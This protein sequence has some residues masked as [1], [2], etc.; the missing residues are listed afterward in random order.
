MTETKLES[1]GDEDPGWLGSPA[2]VHPVSELFSPRIWM[3]RTVYFQMMLLRPNS[4]P[5]A[6]SPSSLLFVLPSSSQFL[7]YSSLIFTSVL[8]FSLE[9]S[10][11]MVWS[12][13]QKCIPGGEKGI[14]SSCHPWSVEETNTSVFAE[15]LGL[16]ILC[17]ALWGLAKRTISCV[18]ATGF[19]HFLHFDLKETGKT[20]EP[21]SCSA[22]PKITWSWVWEPML[23]HLSQQLSQLSLTACQG[24]PLCINLCDFLLLAYPAVSLPKR[25]QF[26]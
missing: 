22:P 19:P 16:T 6:F 20:R 13:L 9:A 21:K 14:L 2:K 23:L 3:S 25:T 12:L 18:S 17:T 4:G 26:R 15:A 5:H 11:W 24:C 8:L 7:L 10:M 1:H